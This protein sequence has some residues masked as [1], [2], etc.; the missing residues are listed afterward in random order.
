MSREEIIK[1]I[2]KVFEG[3][4]KDS[5]L[6]KILK[7]VKIRF[8][9]FPEYDHRQYYLS[10]NDGETNDIIF[11]DKRGL[12]L[13][14]SSAE[15]AQSYVQYLRFKRVEPLTKEI[16]IERL[17]HNLGERVRETKLHYAKMRE[18]EE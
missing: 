18:I 10:D 8:T 5:E 9:L 12:F 14:S 4:E 17:N 11:M 2:E 7:V 15:A 13:S 1:G 16:A 3:Y 6:A